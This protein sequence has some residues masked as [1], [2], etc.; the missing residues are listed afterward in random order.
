FV[1]A[2]LFWADPPIWPIWLLFAIT[3]V[4]LEFNAVEVNDRLFQ[5]SGVMVATTAGT[6]FALHP[7]ASAFA[8]MVLM[9]ALGPFVPDDFKQKRW[10]QPVANFGQMVVTAGVTGAILDVL[11]AGR[12][13]E[14][15][16]LLIVALAGSFGS[17]LYSL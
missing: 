5:S 6:Y 16:S 3:F 8:A 14:T 11:L 4:A 2:A 7:D 1:I 12:G 10:F 15:S 9:A 17:A 13:N